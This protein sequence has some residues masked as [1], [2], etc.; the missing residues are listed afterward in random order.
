MSSF[1]LVLLRFL[2][3]SLGCLLAGLS[4]WG[5]SALLR[6][7]LP[8]LAAQR[9][10]WLLGQLTVIGTF[11][12]ILLPHSE[13]VRLL[14]PIEGATETVSHY[15]VP[16]APAAAP[17]QPVAPLVQAQREEHPWLNLAAYAWLAAYLLG[18]A[19]TVGRLLHGQ[20]MLNRLAGSGHGLPQD[21][22]H[23]GFG[24]ELA[25]A[26]RAQVIE[27]DAP[28]SPMLLGPLRPRLLLP[29]H[30]REFDAM[31]QQMIVEHELTHLRRCDLQWMTLG[32]VL[33]TLLWFNPFMRLLRASLGWA[34]ELGCDRDVLRGRP[35]AQRKVY[36]AALLAQ[37]K[38]QV[39]PPEMALAFGSIDASTLASRLALIRQP[40]SALRGRWAR[41]AGVAAL[42][43]LAAGNFALQSALAGNVAP[44]LEALAAIRCTQLMDAASGRVLQREGQ[45]EARVTPASTFNIAV[46]LMGYDSGFLR[47]EHT[48]VLPFKEGYPAWIPEWRQ[49]LDPSG[50]I[51]YSS[52]WYAQQ[53][54]RQ[55]GAARFQR[56]IADF[57][58]GNRDVAGD[59]GAD[60]G[61]GYAWINSSLKISGDEQVAFLGRMAR[62]ELPLQPQAYEMSARLFKLASFANG[63]EVY[64]KTGTGYPVKADGKEDK[65]RAYGWFVGWAA[66]GGRTIVFAYLVQDQ[67]EEEGAAGPR[68]RAAVLNQLPAQLETL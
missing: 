49:D 16:A 65:T 6:R 12:L 18:L 10:I 22:A 13:R 62:R 54:T 45:C 3:A 15:L 41:W 19:Y 26:S 60:N 55:L 52:V 66:K 68:L 42:A 11:V 7:Y 56:Y 31:Q 5:L 28:I 47:D 8:A 35:A 14:L 59:A 53:V 48:P 36:A 44:D 46:S 4:V 51:K 39:R 9:S 40:G 64:G 37:L 33:Q 20:R 23:A 27:V 32:L 25:R 58:Y 17:S 2:L 30:L 38:L 1:D 24:S 21:E 57:G 63:W 67:K 43:G 61:L 34:Q 50:W 29:R